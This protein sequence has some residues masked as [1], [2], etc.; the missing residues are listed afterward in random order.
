MVKVL[1]EEKFLYKRRR[2]YTLMNLLDM[3]RENNGRLRQSVYDEIG[4]N[5][6]RKGDIIVAKFKHMNEETSNWVLS[7]L[8]KLRY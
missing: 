5:G 2:D 7:G 3:L 6:L 4:V 1:D 8:R